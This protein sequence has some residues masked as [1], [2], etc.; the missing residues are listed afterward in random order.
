MLGVLYHLT[1][2][3]SPTLSLLSS[4]LMQPANTL[5]SLTQPVIPL[6]THTLSS[7]YTHIPS[8]L[9]THTHCHPSTCSLLV[10]RDDLYGAL[11][12]RCAHTVHLQFYHLPQVNLIQLLSLFLVTSQTLALES[13]PSSLPCSDMWFFLLQVPHFVI[14]LQREREREYE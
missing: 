2:K 11:L 1:R 4:A 10:I 8:S 12:F 13:K 7:L 14:A 6:H 3:M 5:L 9:Y